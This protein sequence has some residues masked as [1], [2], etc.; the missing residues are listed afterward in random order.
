MSENNEA[1]PLIIPKQPEYSDWHCRMFGAVEGEGLK[2]NPTKGNV[3]NFFWRW[4]QK[5]CFGNHWY[6][7]RKE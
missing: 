3:P 6:I 1:V 2:W 5:I 4:M 7:N